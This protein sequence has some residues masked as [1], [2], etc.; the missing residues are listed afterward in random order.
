MVQNRLVQAQ[1]W[2]DPTDY[3]GYVKYNIFLPDINN[4]KVINE[5]YKANLM[6][7]NKF[8]MVKF[9]KD[10]MVEPKESQHFGKYKKGQSTNE[11]RLQE[12][13]LYKEDRLGL[14]KMDE[15][16]KLVFLNIDAEHLRFTIEWLKREIIFPY[17]KN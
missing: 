7:L 16:K 1:Y 3:E 5:K 12:T 6:S 9:L 2:N 17:L 14:R 10:Q 8:V 11:I 15:D 4:E 13:D